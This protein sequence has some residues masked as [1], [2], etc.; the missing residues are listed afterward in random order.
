MPRLFFTQNDLDNFEYL[1]RVKFFYNHSHHIELTVFSFSF[2]ESFLAPA[3]N[4]MKIFTATFCAL[5]NYT[6]NTTE[7]A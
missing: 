5:H 1:T 6:T 7:A 4:G 3:S 2:V